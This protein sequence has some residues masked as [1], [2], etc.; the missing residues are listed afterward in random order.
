[1]KPHFSQEKRSYYKRYRHIPEIVNELD[2]NK[3]NKLNQFLTDLV[4]PLTT[5]FPNELIR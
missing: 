2:K 3:T 1:M 4:M 5:Y